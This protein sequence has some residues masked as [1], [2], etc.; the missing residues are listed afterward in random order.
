VHM[1][2]IAAASQPHDQRR[3]VHMLNVVIRAPSVFAVRNV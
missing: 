1:S 3:A 2:E